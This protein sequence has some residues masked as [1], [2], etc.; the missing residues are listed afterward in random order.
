MRDPTISIYLGLWVFP[1]EGAVFG[2]MSGRM[3][4]L[5][6]PNT[7]FH[8]GDS[9]RARMIQKHQAVQ[10]GGLREYNFSQENRLKCQ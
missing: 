8:H 1:W 2:G 7:G 6:P 3:R 10:Q 4:P 5:I 9:Q